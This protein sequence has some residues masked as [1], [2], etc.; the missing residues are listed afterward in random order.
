MRLEWVQVQRNGDPR[1][2]P[3]DYEI[4]RPC[5]EALGVNCSPLDQRDKRGQQGAVWFTREQA[6]AM[7]SHRH[8]YDRE[9]QRV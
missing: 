5:V 1:S 7:R 9:V 3:V 4:P 6:N 2:M 8:A